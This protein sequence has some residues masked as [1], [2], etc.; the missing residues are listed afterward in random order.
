M[1]IKMEPISL[2]LVIYNE[3]QLLDRCLR[4]AAGLVNEIV[5]IHDGKCTDGSKKIAKKYHAK[6]I[7]KPRKC[8]AEIHRVF[9]Y[10]ETKNNW[11]MQLDAD[12]YLSEGLKKAIPKLMKKGDIVS[13]LWERHFHNNKSYYY[14]RWFLFKKNKIC[15]TACAHEAIKKL[16]PNV[17][18]VKTNEVIFHRPKIDYLANF[19]KLK[20]KKHFLWSKAHAKALKEW[21]NLERYNCCYNKHEVSTN[22]LIAKNRW[23]IIFLVIP[24]IIV[25]SWIQF[26]KTGEMIHLFKEPFNE[27]KYYLL[28][29]KE[30]K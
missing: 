7:E 22:A 13:A 8:E 1:Q 26:F 15:F 21:K 24:R 6:F 23:L 2:V 9:S 10:R 17:K 14:D 20:N 16:N 4:S 25:L 19:Q 18:L 11:I 30:M 3:E 28:V 5:I 12:E 29:F 27:V